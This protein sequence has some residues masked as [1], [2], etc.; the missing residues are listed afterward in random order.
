MQFSRMSC[1]SDLIGPENLSTG[2]YHFCPLPILKTVYS[3]QT[4]SSRPGLSNSWLNIVN[5]LEIF[6]HPLPHQLGCLNQTTVL[7]I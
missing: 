3:S 1:S 2:S 7:C 5:D 4:V 6:I